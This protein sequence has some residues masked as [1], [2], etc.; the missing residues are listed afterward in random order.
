[1][2]L[3]KS[4]PKPKSLDQAISHLVTELKHDLKR[5]YGRVNYAR[6][7]KDGFSDYLL[8]RLKKG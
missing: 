3:G 4:H 7:R 6:L 8:L 5:K 2:Q 1:M